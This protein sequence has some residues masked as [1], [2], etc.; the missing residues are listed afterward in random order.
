MTIR[1][2]VLSSLILLAWMEPNVSA[3]ESCTLV[4]KLS[5]ISKESDDE[6]PIEKPY[7]FIELGSLFLK[8]EL[9]NN[10]SQKIHILKQDLILYPYDLI[11]SQFKS[12]KEINSQLEVGVRKRSFKKEDEILVIEPGKSV[13]R[14]IDIVSLFPP[15]L[16]VGRD[17]LTLYD[18]GKYSITGKVKYEKL[19]GYEKLLDDEKI[20]I[21]HGII[22]FEKQTFEVSTMTN[23]TENK[24]FQVFN[25]A[26]EEKKARLAVLIGRNGNN[27]WKGDYIKL[28]TAKDKRIR[29]VGCWKAYKSGKSFQPAFQYLKN[30]AEN[31]VDST[32]KSYAI[33]A[34]GSI[35]HPKSGELLIKLLKNQ[36]GGAYIAAIR[37]LKQLK[38]KKSV[39]YL[40]DIQKKIKK[41]WVKELV[42][43]VINSIE[44]N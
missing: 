10:S 19:M 26:K 9:V 33:I 8:Y 29:I 23:D 40:R 32:V 25:N 28:L 11:I 24:A 17:L 7:C 44:S 34:I 27:S 39:P 4:G 38:D 30:I 3:E 13:S 35:K 16:S 36:E 12:S 5:L 22:K 18:P 21:W 42:E 1:I 20:S 2:I 15:E 6:K 14:I 43:D 41:A 37:G 31:D